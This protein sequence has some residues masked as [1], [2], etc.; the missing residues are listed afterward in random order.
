MSEIA[1]KRAVRCGVIPL[2]GVNGKSSGGKTKSALLLARGLVGPA[3]KIVG[4]DTENGRMSHHADDPAIGGFDTI[5][6]QPPFSPGRYAEA[7]K[8]VIATGY[9]VCVVDSATHEWAGEGGCLEWQADWMRDKKDSM[10]MISWNELGKQRA[11]FL[12]LVL[13]CP[14]ALILCFRVKDKVIMPKVDDTP[15]VPGEYKKKQQVTFEEDVPIT[16][17]DLV[18]EMSWSC[19]VE[20]QDGQGGGYFR[21]LKPG[22]DSLRREFDAVKS[23]RITVEHGAAIARWCVGTQQ[24]STAGAGALKTAKSKLWHALG[25]AGAPDDVPTREAWLRDQKIIRPDQTLATLT[26]E[27]LTEATGKT[28]NII[29]EAKEK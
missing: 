3:G 27:E 5:D 11:P 4:I 19:I 12:N 6:L 23:D 1:I 9:K 17:K 21:V 14:I 10:K 7:I 20:A 8:Q 16:R 25:A 29:K 15:P 13:R 18:Y 22:P 26:V 24:P 2:I 28:E